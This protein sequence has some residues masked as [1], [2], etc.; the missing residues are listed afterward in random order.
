MSASSNSQ[1]FACPRDPLP[2]P[3]GRIRGFRAYP[4]FE[5]R[6]MKSFRGSFGFRATRYRFHVEPRQI[7]EIQ[8]LV[9]FYFRVVVVRTNPMTAQA[10]EFRAFSRSPQ[11]EISKRFG[12]SGQRHG[13]SHGSPIL[14]MLCILSARLFKA[15]QLLVDISHHLAITAKCSKLC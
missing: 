8:F 6:R 5:L 3:S 15:S 4:F 7:R 11:S 14:V 10:D 1:A 2:E 13:G 9:E 12:S